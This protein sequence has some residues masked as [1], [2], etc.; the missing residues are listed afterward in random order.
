MIHSVGNSKGDRACAVAQD[1]IQ[2]QKDHY[3]SIPSAGD[4]TNA[5]LDAI[6]CTVYTLHVPAEILKNWKTEKRQYQK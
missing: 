2:I 6:I 5:A 4:V 1:E 3:G